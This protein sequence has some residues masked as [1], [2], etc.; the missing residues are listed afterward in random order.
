MT[1]Y[2]SSPGH[3]SAADEICTEFC[4]MDDLYLYI[5]IHNNIHVYSNRLACVY[6]CSQL[7]ELWFI[8]FITYIHV[9][10]VTFIQLLFRDLW[11]IDYFTYCTT[12]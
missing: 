10:C 5:Y 7:R 9:Q 2:K 6:S 4:T 8:D 1:C 3:H 11:Y 12:I